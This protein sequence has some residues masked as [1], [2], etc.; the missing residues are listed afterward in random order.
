MKIIDYTK[1]FTVNAS[2]E[3]VTSAILHKVADWWTTTANN[4]QYIGDEL[5]ATFN[6]EG[7][8]FMKMKVHKI[9]NNSSIHWLVLDDNLSLDGSIPKG[10]WVGTTIIWEMEE[11]KEGTAIYFEHLGLNKKLVCYA[12]CENGWNHFL[13][14]LEQYLNTGIGNPAVN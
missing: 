14:S 10:E 12:V 9:E 5:L 6:K 4:T 13:G 3:K 11:A 8:L 7:T 1:R 2:L